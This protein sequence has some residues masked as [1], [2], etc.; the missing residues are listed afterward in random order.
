[1]I[2]LAVDAKLRA[3]SHGKHALDDFAR[4]F[5]GM[6]NG[7]WDIN[8]YTFDDVVGTLNKIAPYDWKTFLRTRLDGH[9]KITDGIAAEGWKLVY[10]DKPSDIVGALQKR[11]H[12]IDFTWSVG[13]TVTDKGELRDV[14]WNGPAF[15][16][17]LAPG[18]TIVGVDGK[19]FN[20]DNM[21]QA[22]TAAKG[23]STAITLLV[24]D[25]DEFKTL[26]VDYHDGLKYPHLVRAEGAPDYLSQLYAPK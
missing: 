14:R 4:A 22:I 2:W 3:L 5:Y 7:A 8:T 18:M 15:K 24:K 1:M 6:D 25:F 9:D 17:G 19:D 26:Q 10:T 23:G 16:A 12:A 21:K 11:Y 13:F 20:G